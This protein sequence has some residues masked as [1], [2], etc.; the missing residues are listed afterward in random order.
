LVKK[1]IPGETKEQRKARKRLEKARLE[2]K[3]IQEIAERPS[4]IIGRTA[5]VLGNGTSREEIDPVFL[6]PHGRIY[7]CNALY[8]TFN[9]DYLIAVDTKMI[10]EITQKN[11]HLQHGNVWTNP[12]KYTRSIPGLNLFNPNLGWS[13]GPTAL[14]LASKHE[15]DIIYI[16]GFDYEGI[17]NKKELV[18]N[19]YAGTENYKNKNDK[20]TYFGNWSRQTM[21]VLKQNSNTKYIRVVRD[22]D[23][24]LP[25]T[26]QGIPNLEHVTVKDFKKTF[27][28]S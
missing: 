15:N 14:N 4:M 13:S 20:A 27:S 19:L 9:P 22:K 1:Y 24:F 17:G 12:N 2:Q 16:L 25:E 26:L 5:F 23:Y 28:I 10:R 21:T 11:F 8:R 6:R 18:N 7:G 3:E